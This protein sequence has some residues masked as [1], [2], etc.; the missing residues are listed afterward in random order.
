MCGPRKFVVVLWLN[1]FDSCGHEVGGKAL[2]VDS[3]S[4]RQEIN[5]MVDEF[6]SFARLQSS[7]ERHDNGPEVLTQFGSGYG[8]FQQVAQESFLIHTEGCIVQQPA[9]AQ[10]PIRH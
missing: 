1:L 2:D 9:T 7:K 10:S 5:K 8:I 6:V 3:H 4:V